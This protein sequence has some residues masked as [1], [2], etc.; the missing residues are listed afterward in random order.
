MTTTSRKRTA[1][2]TPAGTGMKRRAAIEKR[3]RPTTLVTGGTGFLGTHLLRQ[4]INSGAKDIRVMATNIPDW[5]T[6][7]SVNTV[8]GSIT[9]AD[10]VARAVEGIVEIYHLAGKVSREREDAREMYVVHVDGTRVL[11]DAAREAGVK[12]IV[13]ASTSGTIAVTKEGDVIPD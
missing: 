9:N 1:R 12:T 5:L 8:A 13:L 11:S 10:D 3:P 2:M 7:L 4:L 6:D